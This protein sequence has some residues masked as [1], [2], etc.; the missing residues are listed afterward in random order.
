MTNALIRLH[1]GFSVVSTSTLP[2]A[3]ARALT[4]RIVRSNFYEL[5]IYCSSKMTTMFLLMS[6][7]LE[8]SRTTVKASHKQMLL[9]ANAILKASWLLRR[10]RRIYQDFL[11]ASKSGYT[12]PNQRLTFTTLK[13]T[14]SS[15]TTTNRLMNV[16]KTLAILSSSPVDL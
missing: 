8:P 15:L 13:V 2:I 5:V 9:M 14:L 12:C 4:L 1:A 7:Y 16:L 6:L 11:L 3:R 10:D